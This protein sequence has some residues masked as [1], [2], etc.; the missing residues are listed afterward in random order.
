MKNKIVIALLLSF[1]STIFYAQS[2]DSSIKVGDILTIGEVY[3]NNYKYINFP[4]P[5]FIIK[6]GGIVNY[7]KNISKKVEVILIK[8]REDGRIIATIKLTS[9]KLFFNS[10]K[11]VTTDV[12]EAI[13]TKEL[14]K[15]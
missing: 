1:I 7:A 3:N 14:L 13:R 9:K 4:K 11:Y 15:T 12:N 5:N 6:K 8:E 10:H 2:S